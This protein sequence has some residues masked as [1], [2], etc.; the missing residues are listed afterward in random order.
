MLQ[1]GT[2]EGKVAIVTGGGTGLGRAIALRFAALGARVVLASRRMENLEPVARHIQEA[3]GEALAVA[4]DVRDVGQVERMVAAAV[5]RF[6]R[7]DI[8]VNNAAGNFRCPAEELSPNGWRAVVD[9]VLNGTWYCSSAVGRRWIQ[10]GRGGVILNIGTTA[11]FHSGPGTVHSAAA[12]GG[13]LALTR[14]LAAE[15]GKYGI[16]INV[17]TPGP[18]EGTGGEQQ[19]FFTPEAREAMRAEIPL[20]RMG[21]TEE[22][23][24]AAAYLVSDYAS[25]VTGAN[26]V[27]DGGRWLHKPHPIERTPKPKKTG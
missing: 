11:A 21:T 19:L 22:V 26:F 25:W 10:E 8:L 6:G 4:T 27:I 18:L 2:L 12:K 1:P 13:V 16:R 7:I 17:L 20:G 3:G 14:A 23:A 15:W 5:D 24:D 9:I